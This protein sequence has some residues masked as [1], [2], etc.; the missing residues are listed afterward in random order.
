MRHEP[1]GAVVA[2]CTAPAASRA[3]TVAPASGRS[4]ASV[5]TRPPSAAGGGVNLYE[6]RMRAGMGVPL[7]VAGSKTILRAAATAAS[8]NPWP[9]GVVTVASVTAPVASTVSVSTT[10]AGSWKPASRAAFG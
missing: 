6:K 4:E 9:T 7:R 2:V 5:T 10:S 1:S 3:V 8:S